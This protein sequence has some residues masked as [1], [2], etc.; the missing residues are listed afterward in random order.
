MTIVI[1]RGAFHRRRRRI[2]RCSGVYGFREEILP[3]K[4]KLFRVALRITLNREEAE[5]IVQ[6]VLLKVWDKR[7]GWDELESIEAYCLVVTRNLAID[8]SEKRDNNHVELTDEEWVSAGGTENPYD[9]LIG[10]ERLRLVH[11][12]INELPEKQRLMVQ[13]RDIEGKNYKEIATILGLTEE[14]VKV[15]LFR[16]RKKIKEQYL[17]IDEYG[18]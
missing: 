12:I 17:Q 18:L 3:L 4:D 9:R 10:N 11:R 8:R 16:A 6:D 14:Q 15:N 7:D 13:L 5:D 1:G 2:V